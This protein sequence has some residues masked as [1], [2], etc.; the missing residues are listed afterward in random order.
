MLR[1]TLTVDAE[2]ENDLVHALEHAIAKIEDGYTFIDLTNESNSGSAEIEQL[3]EFCNGTGEITVGSDDNLITKK[4][5]N[6]KG[7]D[8]DA[9]REGK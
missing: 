1:L 8:Y 3:C 6:C 2:G 9:Q 5:F 7:P 4:C